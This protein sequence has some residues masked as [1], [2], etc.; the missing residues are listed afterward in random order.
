MKL[1]RRNFLGL[2]GLAPAVV[3][4]AKLPDW[5]VPIAEPT[6][7]DLVWKKGFSY[8]GDGATERFIPHSYGVAPKFMLIKKKEG[9]QT[10]DNAEAYLKEEG[11]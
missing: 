9:W 1:K 8:V 4:A 7:H 3:I 2:I 6:Y 5:P 11:K 10:Y